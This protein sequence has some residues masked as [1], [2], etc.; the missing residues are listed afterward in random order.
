[1][2]CTHV[3][4]AAISL[5]A[6]T[7]TAF[8]DA[9]RS[10]HRSAAGKEVRMDQCSKPPSK[11]SLR[12]SDGYPLHGFVWRHAVADSGAAR[13]LAIINPATSVRCRY[14]APFAAYLHAHGFDVISY[15]YR[16][17]GESRPASLRGF[18]AS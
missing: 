6:C 16:G 17:I 8:N 15:D 14:Y 13:P 18:N 11:F 4:W 1:M 9:V 3:K 7:R 12:A 5:E 2:R 10:T